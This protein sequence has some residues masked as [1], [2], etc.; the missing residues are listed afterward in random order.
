[1]AKRPYNTLRAEIIKPTTAAARSG[2]LENEVMP[3]AEKVKR[4]RR[5]YF[6]DPMTLGGLTNSTVA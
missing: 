2:I 4:F 3:I 6:V 1:M 5:R